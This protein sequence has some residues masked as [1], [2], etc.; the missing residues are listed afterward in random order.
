MNNLITHAT[1]SDGNLYLY[2]VGATDHGL[3]ELIYAPHPDDAA[4]AEV[5]N[6]MGVVLSSLLE[7]QIAAQKPFIDGEIVNFQEYGLRVRLRCVY[8]VAEFPL[9]KAVERYGP[10]FTTILIQVS[11][12]ARWDA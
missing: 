12:E 10:G 3:P 6:M 11:V 9:V 2:S 4:T 1:N 7:Q 8:G 5:V